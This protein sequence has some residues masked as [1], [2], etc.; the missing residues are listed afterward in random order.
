MSATPFGL[1][2]KF[3]WFKAPDLEFWE[4]TKAAQRLWAWFKRT[5]HGD[6]TQ[7]RFTDQE[8]AKELGIGRRCVQYALQW[9]EEQG[10]IRRF[11]IYGP[12]DKAGRVIE[13]TIE[14]AGKS[15]EPKAPP[16]SRPG[17]RGQTTTATDPAPPAPQPEPQAEDQ[18][19]TTQDG[20]QPPVDWKRWKETADALGQATGPGP[21]PQEVPTNFAEK[22]AQRAREKAQ[23]HAQF[24][25][26]RIRRAIQ[27]AER[28]LRRYLEIPPDRRDAL[29]QAEIARLTEL[30]ASLEAKAQESPP[31]RE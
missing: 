15:N 9:L 25:E 14:L 11:K 8:L 17:P 21:E 6:Q 4:W 31:A 19:E 3:A 12:R 5:T 29:I 7:F 26:Q 20:P 16:P 2:I 27:A 23:D 22:I 24:E 1:G 30:K 13:I 10:I 18:P 28:Q